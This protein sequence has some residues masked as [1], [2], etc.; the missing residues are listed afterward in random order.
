MSIPSTT[1]RSIGRASRRACDSWTKRAGTRLTTARPPHTM[2]QKPSAATP[3]RRRRKST[4]VRY[5][6]KRRRPGRSAE[7]RG[8][9]AQDPPTDELPRD[10]NAVSQAG[11][12]V[13]VQ[14]DGPNRHDCPA[15][16]T[17]L[18]SNQHLGGEGIVAG[19]P[20]QRRPAACPESTVGALRVRVF[21]GEQHPCHP[22]EEPVSDDEQPGH[23]PAKGADPGG[24]IGARE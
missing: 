12:L 7:C 14:V 17:T 8:A 1:A 24:G 16:R 9:S 10:S 4:Y 11:P 5:A 20:P 19:V 15:D 18:A 21:Q 13:S 23:R 3:K 6:M 22:G 2:A